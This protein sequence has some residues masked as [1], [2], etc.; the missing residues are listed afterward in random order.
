MADRRGFEPPLEFP[1][2][3]LSRR[4]PS[5]T[6]PPVL[7][8]PHQYSRFLPKKQDI[9]KAHRKKHLRFKAQSDTLFPSFN[10][11]ESNEPKYRKSY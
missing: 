5:T 7:Q 2:N 10:E 6:R 1:L 8:K 9:F 3:T 4:A 11:R